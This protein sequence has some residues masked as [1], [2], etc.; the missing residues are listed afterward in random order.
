M[1]KKN[2]GTEPRFRFFF[3]F[4]G[5]KGVCQPL[6]NQNGTRDHSPPSRSLTN[7][8]TN[9]TLQKKRKV[10]EKAK[11][12]SDG[13]EAN[14]TF[15]TWTALRW[16]VQILRTKRS[17][18]PQKKQKKNKNPSCSSVVC[19]GVIWRHR[20]R[21]LNHVSGFQSNI[22]VK[23]KSINKNEKFVDIHW[24]HP[25]LQHHCFVSA[26]KNRKQT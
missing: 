12:G 14:R 24:R 16:C 26:A 25:T 13:N 3:F 4:N 6:W 7:F 2:T 15:T 10:M 21:E 11:K 17:F 20:R 19:P 5:T 8:G 18:Y 23:K 22:S 1:F 9:R